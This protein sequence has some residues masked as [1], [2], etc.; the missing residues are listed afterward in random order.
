MTAST[1]RIPSLRAQVERAIRHLERTLGR[2]ALHT[3]GEAPEVGPAQARF[4]TGVQALDASCG[5]GLGAG[6]HELSGAAGVGKTTLALAVVAQAQRSG[7]VAAYLDVECALE[8]GTWS[9]VGVDP[10]TLLY[11]RPDTAEA[12]LAL[13]ERALEA[14][15]RLVALDSVAA[16]CPAAERDAALGQ[17]AG[18]LQARL[19]A[20]ALRRIDAIARRQG[21]AVLLVNQARERQG[22]GELEPAPTGGQALAAY[23]ASRLLLQRTGLV[24]EPAAPSGELVQARWLKLRGAS[25]GAQVALCMNYERGF[26]AAEA[27]AQA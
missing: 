1:H 4:S 23:A 21:A 16:L 3:L 10:A 14:G 18:P 12:A 9:R 17:D 13:V 11:A 19:L 27:C 22:A 8:A 6:V 24:G 5:G 15:V 25:P 7:H 26:V 2:G 20:R